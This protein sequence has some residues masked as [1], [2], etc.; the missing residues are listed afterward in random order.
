MGQDD[1]GIRT[2]HVTLTQLQLAFTCQEFRSFHSCV[3][4]RIPVSALN[5]SADIHKYGKGIWVALFLTL[6]NRHGKGQWRTGHSFG[7]L[8]RNVRASGLDHLGKENKTEL[9]HQFDRINGDFLHV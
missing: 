8:V 4:I 3:I 2:R 7:S 1:R 5:L 6:G 9:F